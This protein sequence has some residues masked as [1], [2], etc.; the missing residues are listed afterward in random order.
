MSKFKITSLYILLG[1]FTLCL[2]IIITFP[3]HGLEQPLSKYLSRQTGMQI[4]V[5]GI[6]PLWPAGFQASQVFLQKQPFA[7]VELSKLKA[8]VLFLPLF[9]NH[10]STQI[11]A[12][13]W[14]GSLSLHTICRGIRTWSDL[15][16]NL[17][18]T[19]LNLAHI[20]PYLNTGYIKSLAGLLNGTIELC[21]SGQYDPGQ[22]N[23][24]GTLNLTAA[25]STFDTFLIKHINLQ[26]IEAHLPFSINKGVL[27]I[28]R[29]RAH[30]SGIK[31]DMTGTLVLKKKLPASKLN[32][33][34]SLHLNPESKGFPS[35]LKSFAVRRELSIRL[36]GS[37]AKPVLSGLQ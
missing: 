34:I 24:N 15:Q 27:K 30:A 10:F 16:L 20:M 13:L 6:S 11:D 28:T 1:L 19:R 12:R 17:A 21:C 29:A 36:K 7:P 35:Q 9:S 33:K 31:A 2:T 25:S 32:L 26:S 5:T 4:C 3:F 14:Q 18:L 8:R 22:V 23:G 37:L